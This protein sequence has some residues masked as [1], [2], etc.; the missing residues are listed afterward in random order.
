M[1][2]FTSVMLAFA[3]VACTLVSVSAFSSG[4]EPITVEDAIKEHELIY[5]V[6]L[7]KNRYYFLMPDGKNGK[8]SQDGV[9][10]YEIGDYVSSWYN[11]YTNSAYIHWQ[12]SGIVDTEYP[13]YLM[14]KTNCDNVY[15]ADIPVTITQIT[16][17]NG[18]EY[19]SEGNVASYS[20]KT[21]GI[22]CEYYDPGESIIH[23]D[24]VANFDDMIY[25]I[26]PDEMV[27]A[28]NGT[29]IVGLEVGEW[30]YY[31]GDGCYGAVKNGDSS[32]CLRDDHEHFLLEDELSAQMFDYFGGNEVDLSYLPP[33]LPYVIVYDYVEVDDIVIFSAIATWRGADLAEVV[34]RYGDWCV[35]SAG[36]NYPSHTGMF[37]RKGGEIYTLKEA[38]ENGIVTDLSPAI[39]FYRPEVYPVGDVDLDYEVS[40]LDATLVQKRL[41]QLVDSDA[42]KLFKVADVDE[43]WNLT[44]M[45]ATMIQ[46]FLAQLIPSL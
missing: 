15:Y 35:Y 32:N 33:D 6:T 38:W 31:Y 37:V 1:K 3:I 39:G 30:Y 8:K 13:G 36:I 27:W 44:V 16:I 5:E 24:G 14:M 19:Y 28:E 23:P 9:N 7:E 34:E 26:D 45:D 46:R 10:N 2:K 20:R 17:N 42:I 40:I 25:V 43:D 18:V 21:V 11:S 12:D 4:D 41:A 29:S 22:P